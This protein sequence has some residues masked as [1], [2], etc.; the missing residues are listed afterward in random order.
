MPINATHP[1]QS[2]LERRRDGPAVG[3]AQ[4]KKKNG[5]ALA[6]ERGFLNR[7]WKHPK[8]SRDWLMESLFRRQAS[9]ARRQVEK[10]VT[11]HLGCAHSWRASP[12]TA[13]NCLLPSPSVDAHKGFTGFLAPGPGLPAPA[14]NLS[15][16]QAGAP[17]MEP[18]RR[19]WRPARARRP[20]NAWS[21]Q[22]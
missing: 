13:A 15:R 5:C 3:T 12:L 20:N 8:A 17:A 21:T 7:Q 22:E 16:R 6:P 11:S 9:S 19:A 14:H 4:K 18:S 10:P 1:C 2:S